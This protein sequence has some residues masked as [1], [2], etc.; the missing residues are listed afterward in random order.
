MNQLLINQLKPYK[1]SKFISKRKG[2]GPGSGLGKTCGKGHKGQKSRSGFKIRRGFEGGQTPFY[3][4]IPKFGFKNN[5]YI[6][7]KYYEIRLSDFNKLQD[8][9]LIDIKLL[10]KKRIVPKYVKKVKVILKG[11]L[12]IKNIKIIDNNIKMSNGVNKLLN[13]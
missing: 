6:K 1:K 10:K 5:K 2:R 8:N 7:Q 11:F 12:K 4:R 13:Y 9:L 3:R